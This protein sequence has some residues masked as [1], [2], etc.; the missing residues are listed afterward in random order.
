MLATPKHKRI[1]PLKVMRANTKTFS[2]RDDYPGGLERE[3]SFR[4]VPPPNYISWLK[5]L[6]DDLA[7]ELGDPVVARETVQ[8]LPG[9]MEFFQGS[10]LEVD[11]PELHPTAEATRPAEEPFQAIGSTALPPRPLE[12]V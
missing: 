4:R 9:E 10:P 5:L 3:G 1:I 7:R 8:E 11:H 2:Y 12:L 6:Q